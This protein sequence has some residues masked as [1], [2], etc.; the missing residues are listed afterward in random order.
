MYALQLIMSSKIP[1]VVGFDILVS[2]DW[3]NPYL[4][5]KQTN[6]FRANGYQKLIIVSLKNDLQ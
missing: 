1:F 3:S 2:A 4:G 6:R 5:R